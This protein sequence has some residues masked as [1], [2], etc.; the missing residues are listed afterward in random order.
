VRLSVSNRPIPVPGG[1]GAGLSD[2]HNN[3]AT[4][5]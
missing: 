2:R 1:C 5:G 4:V 3:S